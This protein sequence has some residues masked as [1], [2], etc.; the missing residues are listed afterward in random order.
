MRV[1]GGDYYISAIRQ[2]LHNQL[3]KIIEPKSYDL[4][5]FDDV[6]E[7]YLEIKNKEKEEGLCR[8]VSG[9]AWP[10][11]T[12]GISLAEIKSKDLYD[13]S[14][15]GHHYIWN[16]TNKDWVNSENAMNEIG[17]IHTVQGYDLNYVGVIIGP[18]LKY[19][20]KN[21]ELYID[22]AHY[23]DKNGKN[24][25]KMKKNCMIIFSIY[26]LFF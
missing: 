23:F 13:I 10:W 12:K 25:I 7:M 15:Q 19:D 5:I 17:C 14:I 11:A 2:L 6:E 1:K 21:N 26:I 16:T 18:E 9:Y 20:I 8:M 24:K 22:K 3:Q 4:K